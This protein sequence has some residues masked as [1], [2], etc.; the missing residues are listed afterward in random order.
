MRNLFTEI[1][2]DLKMCNLFFAKTQGIVMTS[3]LDWNVK[4]TDRKKALTG[5]L[6]APLAGK[7]ELSWTLRKFV[8]HPLIAT[9]GSGEHATRC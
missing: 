8:L 6:D 2:C 9:F 4:E 7:S 1:Q 5:G 3:L